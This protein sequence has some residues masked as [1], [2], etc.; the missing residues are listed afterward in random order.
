MDAIAETCDCVF[1]SYNIDREDLDCSTGST[2]SLNYTAR[3]TSTFADI[4]SQELLEF[5]SQWVSS[6]P[7][8]TVEGV[9]LRVVEDKC[10]GSVATVGSDVCPNHRQ[11]SDD[12]SVKPALVIGVPIVGTAL[13][14]VIVVG[15][16]VVVH[17]VVQN[18]KKQ[19]SVEL[20]QQQ[21]QQHRQPTVPQVI[22]K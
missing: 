17:G 16:I 13:L 6:E 5:V 4:D 18:K 20:P 11:T 7:T 10:T 21:Q 22:S 12:G 19:R 15:V 8:I 2:N 9:L 1:T 3:L 14:I